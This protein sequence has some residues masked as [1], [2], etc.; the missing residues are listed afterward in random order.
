LSRGGDVL[1]LV[2]ARLDGVED[3]H[4]YW[5]ARCPVP[6]HEDRKASLKVMRGTEQPVVFHCYAGCDTTDVVT[7]LG[8]TIADVSKPRE[9]SALGEYRGDPIIEIYDYV[10]ERG[11]L[12]FQV[13]R[14]AGKQFPQRRPDSAARSG[15]RWSLGTTRRVP[16]H[17]PQLKAGVR[18]KQVVYIAEGEKDVHA[19]ERVGG[20]ATCNPGGAG[21]WKPDYNRHLH[22]GTEV[23]IVA[24]KDKAGREHAERVAASLRRYLRRLPR[25]V[26][27]AEGKDASDHLGAGYD[28]AG[29]R[30]YSRESV[31]SVSGGAVSDTASDK[32]TAGEPLTSGSDAS[33]TSDSTMEDQLLAGVRDGAW[34]TSQEFPPLR[35]AVPGLIPEGFTLLIGAPKI[36]KSWL[37]L[38]VLLGA[39]AGGLI[40]GRIAPGEPRP[41]FYLALEDSDRRMQD[42]CRALLGDR[43]PIPSRFAYVTRIE[44]GLILATIGAWLERSPGTGLVVVDTLGKV[45]PPAMQGESAYGRDYRIGSAIKSLADKYPGLAIVVCH[46]D[47]KASADDFIDSVSGTHGL[48][49]AADTIAVLGRRR[50]SGEGLLKVTGRDI[51]ENEYALILSDGKAW[52]LDGASLTGAA[53][54]AAQRAATMNLSATSADVIRFI[55]DHPEG[56]R[57]KDIAARFGKDVYQYLGRLVDLGRIDKAGRGFYIPVSEPSEPSEPEVS[58]PPDSDTGSGSVRNDDWPE[59]TIG[60]QANQ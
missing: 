31:R 59:G 21:K 27:A 52:Q 18:A 3:R 39:A 55:S 42:R 35:Y 12:L 22:V 46:H 43:E 32:I 33:D 19:I 2:L 26:E 16:Y 9:R 7:R 47:R 40:L 1:E 53:A 45:M 58:D 5:M 20:V 57:A 29:F 56:V 54:L 50:Q 30:P 37:V 14:T 34:L 10:D 15:W 24:D 60:E 17:L 41:V 51:A 36:G 48:A 28:L 13:C 8:L 11:K 49:G 44:P 23:V 4:G 6:D 25:V 38:D